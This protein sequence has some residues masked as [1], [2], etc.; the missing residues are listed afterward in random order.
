MEVCLEVAPSYINSQQP[1]RQQARRLVRPVSRPPHCRGWRPKAIH[2]CEP[3]ITYRLERPNRF[4]QCVVS[5][6]EA[7]FA[8]LPNKRFKPLTSFAG[9]G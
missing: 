1:R 4:G 8:P 2:P 9:T 6:G 7:Q 3:V 5:V